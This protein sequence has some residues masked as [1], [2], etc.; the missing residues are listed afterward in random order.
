MRLFDR[1]IRSYRQWRFRASV[2][3]S[4]GGPAEV[5]LRDRSTWCIPCDLSA[6]RLGY[7][8]EPAR[9]FLMSLVVSEVVVWIVFN[10]NGSPAIIFDN[11]DAAR[12]EASKFEPERRV[13]SWRVCS[14][15]EF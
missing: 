11:E 7:D 4:C 8:N 9:L 15:H 14:G 6:R 10:E 5:V 2:C 12:E 1:L 13:D 3:E